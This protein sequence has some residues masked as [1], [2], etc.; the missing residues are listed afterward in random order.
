MVIARS[1]RENIPYVCD[2][3]RGL[4]PEQQTTFLLATL[5]NHLMLSLLEL[6]QRGETKAWVEVALTAGL[7]GWENFPDEHGKQTPFRRDDAARRRTLHGIEIAG[8]V[9][10]A[11]LEVIPA[12]LLLELATAVIKA[13]QITGDDAKN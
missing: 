9:P 1:T 13:N 11:T 3:E 4:P 12:N 6:M 7:R 2:A 8:P 5:P 10:A